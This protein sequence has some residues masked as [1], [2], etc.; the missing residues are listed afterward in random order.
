MEVDKGKYNEDDV[1]E[2]NEDDVG[3]DNEEYDED[4]DVGEDNEED[5]EDYDGRA[6]SK[7][8]SGG[9]LGI[10]MEQHSGSSGGRGEGFQNPASSGSDGSIS[11]KQRRKRK[12]LEGNV[13]EGND[14]ISTS[15]PVGFGYGAETDT[16]GGGDVVLITPPKK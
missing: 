1:G 13:D 10:N 4:Y 12:I 16:F 9:P 3:E 6:P 8:G 15:R 7:G 2:D 14:D 5:D 11:N